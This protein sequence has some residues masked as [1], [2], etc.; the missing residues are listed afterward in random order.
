MTIPQLRFGPPT[1]FVPTCVRHRYGFY[2][3]PAGYQQMT[4][5]R[6]ARVAAPIILPPPPIPVAVRK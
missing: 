2:G 1:Y 5:R 6:M 3:G 4:D